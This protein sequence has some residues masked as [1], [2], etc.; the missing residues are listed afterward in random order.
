MERREA[1]GIS[2]QAGKWPLDPEKPTLVFIHGAGG[3]GNLWI[4]QIESLLFRA[5][6]VAVDLPGHGSSPGPGR[7]KIPEY[8][9][10]VKDLIDEIHAP[11]PIL[12]GLS[13]GGGITQQMLLDFPDDF[14]SAALV[15]T[16][17]RLKVLPQIFEKIEQDFEG[18]LE[19]ISKFSGSPKTPPEL[20]APAMEDTK[21]CGPKTALGDFRACNQFDVMGRLSEINARVMVV[22]GQ[23]DLLTPPKYGE[24]LA[25]S[26]KGASRVHIMDTG[27]MIP[28]EKPDQLNQALAEF[29]ENAPGPAN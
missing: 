25:N 1:S 24:F 2:F 8:A 3:S 10:A 22:T 28:L 9:K 13:M 15:S 23:D 27:H 12:A 4:N 7:D 14:D 20:L 26:I 21:I 18:F 19:L 16:G 11:A 17:A 29:V 6:T 5:N